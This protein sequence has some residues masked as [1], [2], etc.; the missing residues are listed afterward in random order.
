MAGSA[1]FSP[2]PLP[3][4]TSI[5]GKFMASLQPGSTLT[6]FASGR[7]L[8]AFGASSTMEWTYECNCSIVEK[9]VALVVIYISTPFTH[10]HT[11]S[12]MLLKRSPSLVASFTLAAAIPQYDRP[13]DIPLCAYSPI[14]NIINGVGCQVTET[15]CFCAKPDI[16]VPALASAVVEACNVAVNSAEVSSFVSSFCVLTS[17]VTTSRR[18]R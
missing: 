16:I 7:F 10:V 5:P 3:L 11:P 12:K 2:R 1:H 13:E 9:V 15:A 8:I 4:Q 17:S 18:T 6:E 14:Q